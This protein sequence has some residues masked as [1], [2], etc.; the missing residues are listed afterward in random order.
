MQISSMEQGFVKRCRDA[1]REQLSAQLSLG[2]S[3]PGVGGKVGS[4]LRHLPVIRPTPTLRPRLL[5]P[6][7]KNVSA[8]GSSRRDYRD[9]GSACGRARQGAGGGGGGG[10]AGWGGASTAFPGALF[11]AARCLRALS[12][13]W[14]LHAVRDWSA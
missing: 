3:A 10:G 7:P 12:R 6:G 11:P 8:S 13:P 2:C 4:G 9:R 1:G 14:E 5:W